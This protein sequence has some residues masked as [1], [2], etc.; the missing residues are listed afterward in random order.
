MHL[1]RFL[2]NRLFF[3]F[4]FHKQQLQ[5]PSTEIAKRECTEGSLP[6]D[7]SVREC[8]EG[9]L[10]NVPPV[11]VHKLP[12]LPAAC[13]QDEDDHR[14]LCLSTRH[15]SLSV[16]ALTPQRFLLPKGS[17]AGQTQCAGT[18]CALLLLITL[19]QA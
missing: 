2:K 5:I 16:Q 8:T 19:L 15:R 4:F 3:F 10:S 18:I 17:P 1:N 11:S 6:E 12:S 9:S 13:P 14:C 7:P